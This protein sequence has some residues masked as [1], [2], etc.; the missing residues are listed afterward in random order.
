MTVN[1]YNI[2]RNAQYSNIRSELTSKNT[3]KKSTMLYLLLKNKQSIKF[4]YIATTDNQH[5][6]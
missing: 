4:R 6:K 5:D 3:N 2:F 1:V